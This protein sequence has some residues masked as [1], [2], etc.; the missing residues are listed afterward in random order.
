MTIVLAQDEAR[1]LKHNYI[2]TEHIFLGLIREEE[3]IAARVLRGMGFT[4]ENVRKQVSL[5]VG[6]GDEI[7]TS[8][9]PFTPR[10][11]KVLDMSL[12]E[13]LSLGCNYVGTEHILL[14]L[15]REQGGITERILEQ[16]K[17]NSDKIRE[18][19]IRSLG[20]SQTKIRLG[21]PDKEAK[22]LRRARDYRRGWT[23]G[24]DSAMREMNK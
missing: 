5:I 2:G 1:D 13:A 4:V 14:G 18:E 16:E 3:G 24:Y 22:D 7:T 15:V 8:E 19:I 6:V 11:K 17:V 23:D 10:A 9:I 12:R 20:V 21:Q